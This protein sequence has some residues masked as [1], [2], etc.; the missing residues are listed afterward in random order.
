[1]SRNIPSKKLKS[2]YHIDTSK[3]AKLD[4][5]LRKLKRGES[6]SDLDV[7]DEAENLGNNK[8]GDDKK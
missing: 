1:M 6:F 4:K 8:N 5:E 7:V 2:E 3:Q